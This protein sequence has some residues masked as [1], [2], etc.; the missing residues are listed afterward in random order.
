[1]MQ[2]F[3][4]EPGPETVVTT[5]APVSGLTE[6]RVVTGAL[7]ASLMDAQREVNARQSAANESL[8]VPAPAPRYWLKDTLDWVREVVTLRVP[9]VRWRRTVPLEAWSLG[10]RMM[11]GHLVVCVGWWGYRLTGKTARRKLD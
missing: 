6:Y 8:G 10:L 1:M 11:R 4:D 2:S 5:T 3:L 7:P 9:P